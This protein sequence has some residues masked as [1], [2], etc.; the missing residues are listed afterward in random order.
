MDSDR[1]S[2]QVERVEGVDTGR[3]RRWSEDEKLKIVLESLQ[4]P[5]QISA[6]ARRYGI[7]R[8]LLIRWRRAFRAERNDGVEQQHG[9]RAGDGGPG[10]RGD[11]C[12]SGLGRWGCHRDRVCGRSS[13]ADHGRGRRSDADSS[14]GC[15]GRWTATMIPLPAGV[16]VWLATGYTDMRKGFPSLALQVQEILQRDPL[17]GHLFCFRGRSGNLLKVIWHDGQGACLF[18]KRL[19]RGRFL[20]PSPAAGAA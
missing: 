6:T 16:R 13:D 14:R 1:R 2:T 7:S 11:A 5:R 12:T 10:I 9:L 20:W 15:T 19:E 4:T 18:T 8:S 3:G 17:S